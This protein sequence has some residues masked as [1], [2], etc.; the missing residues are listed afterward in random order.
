MQG[1]SLVTWG[2]SVRGLRGVKKDGA[3]LKLGWLRKISGDGTKEETMSEMHEKSSLQARQK[4]ETAHT[5]DITRK[6]KV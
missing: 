4:L 1:P 6:K 5:T 2:G 3:S